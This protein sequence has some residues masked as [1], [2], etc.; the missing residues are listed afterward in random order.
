MPE[1]RGVLQLPELHAR[2]AT[3]IRVCELHNIAMS[4]KAALFAPCKGFGTC[5]GDLPD[6]MNQ[7][8]EESGDFS[9]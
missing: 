6:A 3:A 9:V 7:K 5:L 1:L 2:Y 4:G 8:K